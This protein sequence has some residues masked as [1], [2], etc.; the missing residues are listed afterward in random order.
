MRK[1]LITFIMFIVAY[2]GRSFAQDSLPKITVRNFDSKNIISW[3]NGYQQKVTTINIQRSK[4]SSKNFV[5]IGGVLNPL[6]KENGF[7]DN[8]TSSDSFYYRVFVVFEGGGYFFTR[9][10]KPIK[11]TI[12]NLLTTQDFTLYTTPPSELTK[13][14]VPTGFVA[15]KFVY[16]GKDNNVIINLPDA[17]TRKLSLQFFDENDNPVFTLDKITEP[18]LIIEKVNFIHAGWFHYKLY[19]NNILLEKYKFQIIRN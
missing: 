17:A 11:D 6:N 12:H 13:P 8:K 18:Y 19:D 4:D 7:V 1:I 9:S 16:T 15:S 2:T 10:R 14:P 5:T 3:K